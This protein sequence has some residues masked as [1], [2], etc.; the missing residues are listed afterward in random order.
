VKP[1]LPREH[2]ATAFALVHVVPHDPQ[3]ATSVERSTQASPQRLWPRGHPDAHDGGPPPAEGKHSG[4]PE[5]ALHDTS[6]YPQWADVRSD[7]HSPLQRV[8]PRLHA[9]AHAPLTHAGCPFGSP[10]AHAV[11]E[12]PHAVAVLLVSTQAPLQ[13]VGALEGQ[14]VAHAWLAPEG[15]Q[16]GGPPSTPQMLSQA[17]QLS[18]V[19]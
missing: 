4:V 13:L 6:Q 17:P 7:T 15:A 1:Q 18:G 19:P 8:Y 14:V 16:S 2:V 12:G 5:S 11:H 9:T 3:L 10:V